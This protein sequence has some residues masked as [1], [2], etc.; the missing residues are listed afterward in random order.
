MLD[1]ADILGGRM[2]GIISIYL[3]IYIYV[4]DGMGWDDGM[5]CLSFEWGFPH[6]TRVR[7]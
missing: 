6:M 5:E 3:F 1:P 4:Y 7:G 2:T